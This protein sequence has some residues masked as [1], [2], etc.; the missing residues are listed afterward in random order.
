MD[1]KTRNALARIAVD[2]HRSTS[3]RVGHGS[4]AG[5]RRESNGTDNG[6][7]SPIALRHRRYQQLIRLRKTG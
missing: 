6:A 3:S 7:M 5:R 4:D 2:W 1:E